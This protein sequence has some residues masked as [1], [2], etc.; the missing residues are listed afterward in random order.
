[1]LLTCS[2]KSGY[3]FFPHLLISCSSLPFILCTLLTL[4]PVATLAEEKSLFEL[5]LQQLADLEITTASKVPERKDKTASTVSVIT[6]E[7]IRRSGARNFL[8]VLS[9]VPGLSVGSGQYGEDFIAVRGLRTTW[10]EKV[11][12][13]LDGHLLNDVRSG[14]A[15][16]QFLDWLPLANIARIEVVKGPGSALYG[17]NAFLG[18]INIITQRAE[19]ISGT[20]ATVGGEFEAAGTVARR[21]NLLTGGQLTDDWQGSLNLNLL[22]APGAELPVSPDALGRS[23]RADNHTKRFDVQGRLSHGPFSLHGRY[24]KR[25]AGGSFGP[26]YALSND[27]RQQVEYAFVDAEYRGQPAEFTELTVRAYLDHQD[28]DNYYVGL[29]AGT[30]PPASSYFPWNGTGLKG[31]TLAKENISGVETQLNYRGIT[32]HTFHRPGLAP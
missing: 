26:L 23:G 12:L 14:S 6:A 20:Q 13:L 10:S 21:Y 2:N 15:T 9:R 7:E 11:Q 27:S 24:L 17:A 28:S 22:D 5:S 1:M 25:D 29:P 4:T 19:E 31:K 18:V 30:I 3:L 32:D 16:Y 8:D